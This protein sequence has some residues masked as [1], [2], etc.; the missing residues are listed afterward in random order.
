MKC[1][2]WFSGKITKAIKLF[3]AELAYRVVKVMD[4][5]RTVQIFSLVRAFCSSIS[6]ED[7]CY[8]KH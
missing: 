3:S 2:I 6:T 1:Q 8:L 7:T 4:T 5:Y